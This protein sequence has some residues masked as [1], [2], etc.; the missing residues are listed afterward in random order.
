MA[1]DLLTASGYFIY[2]NLLPIL[3]V[4]IMFFAITIFYALNNIHLE[5]PKLKTAKVVVLEKM[6]NLQQ[7]TSNQMHDNKYCGDSVKDYTDPNVKKSTCMALGSCVWASGKDGTKLADV[8]IIKGNTSGVAPGSLGPEDKCFK[9]KRT[10]SSPW[11]EFYYQN[12]PASGKN[13]IIIVNEN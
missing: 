11:E 13:L 4:T 2:N 5:E 10:V 1:A 6:D 9:K 7:A 3:L 12:G 8:Y